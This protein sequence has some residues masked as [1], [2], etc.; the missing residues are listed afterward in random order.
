MTEDGTEFLK[1]GQFTNAI[2]APTAELYAEFDDHG[3]TSAT[4]C[5]GAPAGESA[6]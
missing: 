3:R 2:S 4:A 5:I 1:G 6:G